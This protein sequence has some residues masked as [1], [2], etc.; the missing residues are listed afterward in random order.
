[1]PR[2]QYTSARRILRIARWLDDGQSVS[3]RRV[4]DAFGV[5]SAQA[6]DDLRLLAE[7]TELV[8]ER[9]G[10]EVY[11][12]RVHR[13]DGPVILARSASLA[14]GL[15]ASEFFNGTIFYDALVEQRQATFGQLEPEQRRRLDAM[16]NAVH[17][18][19]RPIDGSA[20]RAAIIEDVLTALEYGA[21]LSV[22]HLRMDDGRRR[23]YELRPLALVVHRGE[24]QVVAHKHPS[25][26]LRVFD[27]DGLVF[28]EVRRDRRDPDADVVDLPSL[29][30]GAFGRYVDFPVEEIVLRLRDRA[31][32]EVRRG[33][34]HPSQVLSRVDRDAVELA[35]RVGACPDL[36]AWILARIPDVDVLHPPEL[37]ARLRDRVLAAARKVERLN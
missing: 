25:G 11:W 1:M 28:A 19:R 20:D 27:L 10:R 9:R 8:R 37:A 30:A 29:Y 4:C 12:R 6:R 7:E 5:Q 16:V 15:A 21:G 32:A 3:Y 26:E 2:N 24:L 36:E 33:P 18:H 23:A 34:I 13:L 14:L 31:A 35:L 17:T 22:V